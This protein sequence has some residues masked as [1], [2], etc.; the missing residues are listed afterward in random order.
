M[1]GSVCSLPPHRRRPTKKGKTFF[2]YVSSA[3]IFVLQY[4]D[5]TESQLGWLF[6]P[7]MAGSML[8]SFL[9]GRAA[10][11]LPRSKTVAYAYV[12][13]FAAGLLNLAQAHL[14]TPAV[15]WAILPL[16]IFTTGM[17]LAM[18]SI[19][20]ATLDLFPRM[21]GMAGSVQGFLQTLIMTLVSSFAP[22]AIGHSG[23]LMAA[24]MTLFGAIGS[25]GWFCYARRSAGDAA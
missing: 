22:P 9:S 4:L 20:L 25:M 24:A 15:P 18:P 13:M 23:L 8:G 3:P 12:I 11:R 2:L 10:S 1:K 7:A 16:M 17:G 14:F 6:I 19:T 5:L 21:R